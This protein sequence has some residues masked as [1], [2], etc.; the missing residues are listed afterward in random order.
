ME[1][2]IN[3]VKKQLITN[4]QEQ[5]RYN[6]RSRKKI[7]LCFFI[8]LEIKGCNVFGFFTN[9]YNTNGFLEREDNK[10][11]VTTNNKKFYC[12]LKRKSN[13]KVQGY[14]LLFSMWVLHLWN[15][16]DTIRVESIGGQINLYT[17]SFNVLSIIERYK[18]VFITNI[19]LFI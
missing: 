4:N 14:S 15:I 5:R 19:Y 17:H 11:I 3:K 7:F 2:K 12:L 10:K 1:V 18:R 16:G 9:F 6:S 8:V 13:W